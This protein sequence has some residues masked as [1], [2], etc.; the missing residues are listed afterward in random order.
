MDLVDPLS[1]SDE[2]ELPWQPQE[3]SRP[4]TANIANSLLLVLCGA[5]FIVLGLLISAGSLALFGFNGSFVWWAVI[6]LGVAQIGSG[7][8]TGFRGIQTSDNPRREWKRVGRA[9]MELTQTLVLAVLIFLAV[10]AMA[11][12]FRVEGASMEPGL[13]NGQ[14]LLVNKAVSSLSILRTAA[15]TSSNA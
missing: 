13:H 3:P 2:S 8:V 11:Q 10:R 7:F 12:N 14:Y 4:R 6:G 9:T 5:A 1:P 15:G